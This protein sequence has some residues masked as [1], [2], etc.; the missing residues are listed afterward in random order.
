MDEEQ[1]LV[2]AAWLYYMEGLTQDRIAEQLGLTRLKVNRLLGE[3]RSSGLVGITINSRLASCVELEAEL[4]RVCG[5][6]HAAIVPT[7]EDPAQI[8]VLLGRA[9]GEFLSRHLATQRV[10]GIGVGWGATLRET[11]RFVKPGHWPDVHVNSMMGGLTRG[12]E[13][14]TFETASALATRLGA[15]CSY[16]AAPLYAGSQK[17]RDTLVAQDVF[18]ESFAEM[19]S[20]DVA[21]LS[22]GDISEQSLLVRYGLPR[23]VTIASLKRARAVGDIVGRFLDAAGGPVDHP[24]NQRAITASLEALAR[25]PTVIVASGGQHKAAIIAAVLHARLPKVLVCD[26]KTAAQ[27]L[28]LYQG[29]G[30]AGKTAP[31]R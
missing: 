3:A 14:N 11:I 21:L 16:L 30:P 20:N 27:A 19:A 24:V 7:P 26:E 8:P 1:V 15:R 13:I 9:A 2:R 23:D 12:L 22:V 10:R 18:Q 28:R 5:L 4:K 31:A 17:S 29:L 6:Q 25:I